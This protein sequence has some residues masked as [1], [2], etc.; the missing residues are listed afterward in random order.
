MPGIEPHTVTLLTPTRIPL[1]VEEGEPIPPSDGGSSPAH[2]FCPRERTCIFMI[3]SQGHH[4]D[5]LGLAALLQTPV[6]APPQWA[7]LILRPYS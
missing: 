4:L 7:R 6:V 5:L 1:D 3:G 2:R